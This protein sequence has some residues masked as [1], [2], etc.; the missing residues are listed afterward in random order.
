M[1][2]ENLVLVE[3]LHLVKEL[4]FNV[5]AIFFDDFE[6]VRRQRFQLY[7]FEFRIAIFNLNLHQHVVKVT[8]GSTQCCTNFDGFAFG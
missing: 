2:D 6:I 7:G 5:F 3:Y 8:A 1:E 4:I